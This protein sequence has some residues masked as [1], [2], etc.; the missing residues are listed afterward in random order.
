MVA[1]GLSPRRARAAP[2]LH[3]RKKADRTESKARDRH[4]SGQELEWQ[5]ELPHD[6][7]YLTRC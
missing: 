3:S 4:T 1:T 7:E 6:L 5:W 2:A